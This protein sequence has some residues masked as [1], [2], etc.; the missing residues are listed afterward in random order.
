MS[1]V[2][3]LAEAVACELEIKRSRFIGRVE[4]IADMDDG[5]QRVDALRLAHPEATHVCYS[6]L[7]GGQVRQSDDGEPS[8]TAARPMLNVLQHK[9]L[10]GVLA[11]VVRYYGGVKLG[12]GGL[13]RAYTQA[14][15]D[16]LSEAVFVEI[17]PCGQA[18]V[19]VDFEYDSMLRRL[20]REAALTVEIH[21]LDHVCATIS[22][23]DAV[24]REWLAMLVE[25]TRGT[26]VVEQD[27][28]KQASVKKAW[29]KQV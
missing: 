26:A 7:V 15:S 29:V 25:Q 2:Q 4:P 6:M 22:G 11:T 20:A 14:I 13:V 1:S 10:D 9:A 12:A 19:R 8:G 21:Y 24:L 18:V 23:D 3:T 16:P 28:V 27:P 5:L 17:K